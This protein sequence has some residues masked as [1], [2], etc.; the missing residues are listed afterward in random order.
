MVGLPRILIAGTHSGVGKTT[1]AMG[2]IAALVRRGLAVQPFKV[3]PDYLDPTHL[4]H[5]AGRA[6]RNLD[7]WLLTPAMV[8][9]VFLQAG[10]AAELSLIE[11]VMGVFDGY[12]AA[13]ERGSTAEVAKLLKAPVILVV[14]ASHMARSVAAMVQGYRDFDADLP[15]AGIILN[16]VSERHAK[17]LRESLRAAVDVPV[18]GYLP[19]EPAVAIPERHL[20]L[21]P[22]QEATALTERVERLARLIETTVDLER[23][24]RIARGAP[25]LPDGPPPWR[26]VPARSPAVRLGIA[27]DR[28][29]HF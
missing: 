10:R 23:V 17:L 21:V 8:R 24:A 9:R 20:G 4:E 25:A 11:G 7:T 29:F 26:A 27:K 6:A 28:A 2:L 12:G 5:A 18:L 22:A 3:G 1:V 13:T 19:A 16:R 14:D 15:L